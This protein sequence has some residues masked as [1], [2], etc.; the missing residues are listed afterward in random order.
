MSSRRYAFVTLLLFDFFYVS[1]E[2]S[3]DVFGNTTSTNSTGDSQVILAFTEGRAHARGEVGIAALDVNSP[4]L[5]L[6]QISDNLHYSDALNKI[7]I[8]NPKKI[9]LPDTFEMVPLPKIIQLIKESFSHINLIPIQRRHFNDKLG[10][11]LITNFCSRKSVNIL[12]VIA[13]KYYC[14]SAA[15]ALLSYLKDVTMMT[16]AKNCLRIEYQTKQG[17]MMIDTQTSARLE[18]LYSLCNEASAIK[19]FSLFS[20][21]NKC[22]TRIGE[23]HLRANILEPSVSIDFIR[24]RQEQIKVL[25]ENEEIF[26]ALKENLQ[27]FRSIDQ[28]LKISCIVPADNY[29]KAIE[30]NIQMALLLKQCLEAVKPLCDVIQST[31]SESFEEIRQLLSAIIFTEIIKKIDEVVQPDIHKNRLAQKHFQHLFAVRANVNETI[32]FLRKLYTETTDKIREYLTELTEQCQLPL[33]LIYS[34]KLGHHLYMKNP[35]NVNIPEYL[36]VIY[37]K[38]SN[39]YITTSQLEALNCTTKM[40][41]SDVIRMSNAILCDMLVGIASEI[42]AIHYLIG[43]IIDLDLVQSLTETSNVENYCCPSFGRVMRIEDASHPM[44]D[45]SRN[46]DDV[47]TNNVVSL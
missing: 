30:Q 7:Q 27:N 1:S 45:S 18:L 11:D 4:T 15:S 28:L 39:V 2:I 17:G 29:E 3:K 42:D 47:I 12:Q 13:R 34:S 22:E 14:L 9:L 20:I 32:D 6:C 5:I 37:R 44:L 33:K 36:N 43:T 40:I 24:N 21:L 38:G 35:N 19:K 46:K 25:M 8:L 31:V 16:F 10:L 41:A 23:R 26:L